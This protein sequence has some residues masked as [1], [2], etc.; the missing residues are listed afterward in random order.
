MCRDSVREEAS[1]GQ[2]YTGNEY[3]EYILNTLELQKKGDTEKCVK[4][5]GQLFH[6]LIKAVN[7]VQL[8]PSVMSGHGLKE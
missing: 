1:G 5:Y 8:S 7:S 3:T 2:I 4:K 6:E